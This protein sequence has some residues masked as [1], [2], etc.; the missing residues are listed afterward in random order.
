MCDLQQLAYFKIINRHLK[1]VY[2]IS[3]RYRPQTDILKIIYQISIRYPQ[4]IYQIS[5]DMPNATRPSTVYIQ[6]DYV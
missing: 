4:D 5:G 2:E 3:K 1:D 6:D